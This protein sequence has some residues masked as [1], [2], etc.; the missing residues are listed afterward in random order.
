[1]KLNLG[2]WEQLKTLAI[3]ASKQTLTYFKT[4]LAVEYKRDN[5]PLT[6]ADR[7]SHQCIV[8][9]LKALTPDIPIVS[10]ESALPPYSER[11]SWSTYWLID[12]LDG[13]KEFVKGVP[14]YTVNIALIQDGVPCLGIVTIPC[15]E[16]IYWAGRGL[17]SYFSPFGGEGTGL[18]IGSNAGNSPL[19]FA[20]SRSHPDPQ[21]TQFL[22][23]FEDKEIIRLGSALK[24]CKVAEQAVDLY[25]RMG[26]IMEW[27]TAAAQVVVEQAGGTVWDWSGNP[28]KYNKETP[29][30]SGFLVAAN[31]ELAQHCIAVRQKLQ[32]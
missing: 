20:I 23:Q 22:D 13:T 4:D 27:D 8:H 7:A 1:M 25:V 14:E 15:Q 19:R 30:H 2:Q 26:P 12:P 9:G 31:D 17:G 32:A 29:T 16:R 28:L 10:E 18:K 24:F 5:S 3:E 21:M 6:E 11:K